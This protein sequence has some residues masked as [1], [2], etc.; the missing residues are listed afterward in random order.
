MQ[1]M[2]KDMSGCIDHG[3]L[4]APPAPCSKLVDNK[5]HEFTRDSVY[6]LRS[7]LEK[8]M[9]N[10]LR[11]FY[12]SQESIFQDIVKIKEGDGQQ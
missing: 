10:L 5:V 1:S 3:D 9:L 6:I 12:L 4:P 8:T 7:D 11:K 2:A